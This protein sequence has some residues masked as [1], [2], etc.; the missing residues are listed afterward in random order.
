MM[1]AQRDTSTKATQNDSTIGICFIEAHGNKNLLYSRKVL[2]TGNFTAC[3]RD[4]LYQR[5]PVHF[6]CTEGKS[7]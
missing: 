6:E 3:L 4:A 2:V 5:S 1:A 7:D